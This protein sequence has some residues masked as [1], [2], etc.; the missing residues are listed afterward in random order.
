[1][2]R[3]SNHEWGKYFLLV[4]VL[5]TALIGGAFLFAPQTIPGIFS[6]DYVEPSARFYLQ[7]LGA[8]MFGYSLLNGFGLNYYDDKRL[9]QIICKANV[10]SLSISLLVTMNGIATGLLSNFA[11]IFLAEHTLFLVGFMVLL[12]TTRI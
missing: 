7:F 5:A 3:R 6:Q 11:W 1:M 8:V 4:T 10:T 12:R 9:R 2:S